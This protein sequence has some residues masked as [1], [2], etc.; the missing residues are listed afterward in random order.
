MIGILSDVNIIDNLV[1]IVYFNA[2]KGSLWCVI[3]QPRHTELDSL[4]GLAL[5]SGWNRQSWVKAF[6]VQHMTR[7]QNHVEGYCIH[8]VPDVVIHSLI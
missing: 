6:K 3:S 7:S 2:S 1:I 5:G 8:R 4:S